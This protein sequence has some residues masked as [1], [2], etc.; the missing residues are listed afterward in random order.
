M[1]AIN[2]NTGGGGLVI[3]DGGIANG[4]D[5]R[6][7]HAGDGDATLSKDDLAALIATLGT[8]KASLIGATL[9]DSTAWAARVG[10]FEQKVLADGGRIAPHAH[11]LM[12]Q[13]RYAAL[14]DE[15]VTAALAQASSQLGA[16]GE[17]ADVF[18]SY[19]REDRGRVRVLAEAL[20]ELG[21][22]VWMDDELAPGASF[23]AQ[24]CDEIDRCRVQIVN[25]SVLACASDWVC[26]E[27]ELGRRRGALVSV[28]IEPCR[29]PPPFNMLHTEDLSGWRGE[30]GHPAWIKVLQALGQRLARPGLCDLAGVV[31]DQAALAAWRTAHP[32]DL[33]N[34]RRPRG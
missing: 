6:I 9:T 32:S 22:S 16:R 8:L 29:I 2:I 33:F 20:R 5:G 7:V 3:G 30:T 18:I 17:P 15:A 11:K 13:V 19:K 31:H 28:Q 24:I 25:W 10:A 1:S 21:V 12:A 27:A 14:R 4:A 23:T 26:G 34:T